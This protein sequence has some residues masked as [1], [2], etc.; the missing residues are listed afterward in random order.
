M[1]PLIRINVS[2]NSPHAIG[3]EFHSIQ[4]NGLV[5]YQVLLG[6]IILSLVYVLIIFELVHRTLAALIGS[7]LGLTALSVIQERPS[8]LEVNSL[9]HT[10]THVIINI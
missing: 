3:M 5:H 2:T 4:L 8:Y 1:L 10:H 7:F 9:S 6:V